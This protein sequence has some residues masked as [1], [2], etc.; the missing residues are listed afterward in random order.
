METWIQL[1]IALGL[2]L[3]IGLQRERAGGG[4][5]GIRTF[6]L[7]CVLGA[8]CALLARG[9]GVWLVPAGLV[10]LG[11]LMVA[12]NIARRGEAHP[13]ATSEIAALLTYC[14]GALLVLGSTALAIALGGIVALLLYWKG[15]L[16]RFAQRIGE[17][18][19]RAVF[20]LVLIGLV[21]LPLLPDRAYGPY[22]V[23]NPFRIWLVVVLI[24]GISLAGY[25][26]ARLLGR[27]TGAI[28]AGALGGVIS[29]TATTV[30]YA[31]QT[32]RERGSSSLAAVVIMVASTVVFVRVALEVAITAPGVLH[33]VLPQLGVMT[34]IMG[35]VSAAAYLSGRGQGA[36]SP[37]S[38]D[39]TDLP[40]AV[41][42]GLLYAAVLFA[43]AAARQYFG[44]RGLYFVAA[45]SGLTDMDAITL[46]TAGM[47]EAGRIDLDTGWRMILVGGLSNIV[48]KGGVVAIVGSR[49]LLRR[50][51]ILFGVSLL[52]GVA[53]L[54]L[55]PEV[56]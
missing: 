37:E 39:P 46:S 36:R 43:V 5:A 33:S 29:S 14:I 54:T 21:V 8:V 32:G 1:G 41:G 24:V 2:G 12:G 31:R 23:L 15:P 7:I 17:D 22:D 35:L 6:P 34:G 11:A 28:V 38:S 30:G 53:L 19:L 4:V 27:Q 13:G 48:F 44:D 52:G 40:A 56:G 10:V 25:V 18:E 9:Y 42:F 51:A 55:W 45:L 3:L 50:I 26:A 20:R 16:H 47:M 49:Q